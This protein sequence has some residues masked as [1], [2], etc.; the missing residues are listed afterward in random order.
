MGASPVE[1]QNG[2]FVVGE[3]CLQLCGQAAAEETAV[4]GTQLLAHV[5]DFDRRQLHVAG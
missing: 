3:G 5:D 1:K 2:L 4:A